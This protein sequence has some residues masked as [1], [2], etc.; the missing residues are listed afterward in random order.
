MGDGHLDSR[1][2]RALLLA[3]GVLLPRPAVLLDHAHELDVAGHDGRDG[4]DERAAHEEV[5][6]AGHV[7]LRVGGAEARCEEA[8]FDI[9]GR[10]GVDDV[11]APGEDVEGDGEVD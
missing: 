8:G 4:G 7:E 11:D 2:H 3:R 9:G 5:G 1:D 6:G 10:Q